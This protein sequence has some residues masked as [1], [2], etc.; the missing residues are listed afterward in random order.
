MR[1]YKREKNT[2]EAE[3]RDLEKR[4][5][6]HDNHLRAIDSWFDQVSAGTIAEL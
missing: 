2:I 5:K 1:E 4:A 6:D 3:L